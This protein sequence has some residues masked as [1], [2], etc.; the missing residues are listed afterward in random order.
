MSERL[1]DL[2]SLSY[3]QLISKHDEHA[4]STQVGTKHYLNEIYRR[5]NAKISNAMLKCTD[6]ML[7][8]TNAVCKCTKLITIMTA[9]ILIATIANIFF[10]G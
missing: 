6:K 8:C 4:Q 3:E 9:I 10:C 1:K 2:R 7:R 5:D